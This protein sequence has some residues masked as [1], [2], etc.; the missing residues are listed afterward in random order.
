MFAMSPDGRSV[1]AA[2]KRGGVLM[3]AGPDS[4]Q[5][6]LRTS[7]GHAKGIASDPAGRHLVVVGDRIQNVYSVADGRRVAQLRTA[8]RQIFSAFSD[9]GRLVYGIDRRGGATVWRWRSAQV[10]ARVS[11]G[12]RDAVWMDLSPDDRRLVAADDHGR[13]IV[14]PARGGRPVEIPGYRQYTLIAEF[15]RDGRTLVT[16]A[17]GEPIRIWNATGTGRPLHTLGKD[18]GGVLSGDGRRFF[19]LTYDTGLAAW[20]I[21]RGRADS[22]HLP[23]VPETGPAGVQMLTDWTGRRLAVSSGSRSWTWDLTDRARERV[24]IPAGGA[25]AL[26]SDGRY[27]A[28]AGAAGITVWDAATGALVERLRARLDAQPSLLIGPQGRWVAATD[29]GSVRLFTCR[30]CVRD[31]ALLQLGTSLMTRALTAQERRK[32]VGGPAGPAPADGA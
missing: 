32:F 8:R 22:V 11:T 19:G 16:A 28:T 21:R 13:I 12:I 24:E 23:P 10:L 27:L 25:L 5:M 20:D 31:K 29:R 1:V 2:G 14:T 4:P 26:S 17:A 15:T 9:D 30:L 7:A 6:V 3:R 18:Y